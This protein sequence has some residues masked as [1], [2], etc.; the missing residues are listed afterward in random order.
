MWAIE[1]ILQPDAPNKLFWLQIDAI[2]TVGR[3]LES[4]ISFPTDKSV[5][6]NHATIEL[7]NPEG[8]DQEDKYEMQ[9]TDLGG[10]YGTSIS[11]NRLPKNKRTKIEP[12]ERQDVLLA[13]HHPSGRGLVLYRDIN[14]I[15]IFLGLYRCVN[16]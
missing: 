10:K 4:Q 7:I 8:N 14:G 12:G 15:C 3:S 9:I 5:S 11:S 2:I 6:R 1:I 16:M 13:M